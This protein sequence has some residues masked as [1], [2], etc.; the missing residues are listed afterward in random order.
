MVHNFSLAAKGSHGHTS[1]N[2]LAEADQVCIY[3]V[4]ANRTLLAYTETGHD[5][6][7]N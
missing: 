5:F 1:A 7:D 3:A 2:Y 6:I 4:V